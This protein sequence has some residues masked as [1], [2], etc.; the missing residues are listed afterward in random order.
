MKSFKDFNIQR[1][2]IQKFTGDK[3]KMSK[4]INK[5]ISVLD[6][7]LEKSKFNED[8]R[9]CIQ[10]AINDTKYIVF[11]QAKNLIDNIQQVR[12]EDFPFTT[13]IVEQDDWFE[14]T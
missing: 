3:M 8:P 12:K 1:S 9:L 5:E 13:T 10:F 2:E 11:T 6:F 4:I 7:K 14:F